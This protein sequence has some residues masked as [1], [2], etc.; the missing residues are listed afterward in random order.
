VYARLTGV[1][2]KLRAD[3]LPLAAGMFLQGCVAEEALFRGFLFAH[4]RRG[5]T[6][7]R[8]AWLSAVPF[9]LVH[10]L[11][12]ITLDWPVAA[13]ALAI[14]FPLA[15]TFERSGES[16]WPCALLHAAFASMAVAWMAR[17]RADRTRGWPCAGLAR[18]DQSMDGPERCAGTGAL[19][20]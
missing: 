2:V 15:W 6:F 7:W 14:S 12:F 3:A 9:T 5:R 10:A 16:I 8:A 17:D 1:A 4:M 11:L 13:A 20:G 19:R 18:D